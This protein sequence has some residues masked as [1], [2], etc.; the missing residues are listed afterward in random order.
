VTDQRA[1]DGRPAGPASGLPVGSGSLPVALRGR[2][3]L[4]GADDPTVGEP[5]PADVD[6]VGDALAAL[7]PALER[8][9]GAAPNN[10]VRAYPAGGSRSARPLPEHG[11]G[12]DVVL[13]ELSDA[14]DHGCRID[15]PGWFGFVTTG[16]T[17]SAV[18]AQ[19]AV[20]VAGGQRY[21][22]HA[23]NDL[24]WTALRWLAELCGIPAEA[25]GVF[26]SGGSTAN[27]V[28][29]GAARQAAFERIGVDVAEHGLPPGARTRI[30]ASR[31]AHRTIHRAAAALGLGRS[32]VREIATDRAGHVDIDAL[33][34]ALRE[35]RSEGVV[36]VAVVGVAGTTDTG[37][38]DPLS[39][40]VQVARDHDCWAH[41]DGAYGLMAYASRSARRLF[42]GV[43]D[44][45]SWIVD[46]H[47]WLATGVG[48]GAAYVRDGD[49]L[50]R[51]FS[52]GH[53]DY[54]EGS[55]AEPSAD[56]VSQFDGIGGPWADQ[57]VELS[58]P[59]RGALVWA[60]LREI[61]R[62]GVG[63]RVD[64]HLA[65]TR[66]LADQ[67]R[68][69]PRLEMLCEP[70]LSI[71]C[72][73]YK[74]PSGDPDAINARI[75]EHLRRETATVPTSTLVDGA[76]ALRPCIINPRTSRRD[77]DDLVR[78]TVAIGDTLSGATPEHQP[79]VP[80]TP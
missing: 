15:M 19:A 65:L 76:F 63:Q 80:G 68:R 54:L 6:R 55:F 38:V 29:L 12:L 62:A 33:A 8:A 74:P 30:Y 78:A 7:L 26:T 71:V 28:A 50:T 72:Y 61:G 79:S 11:A 18:A 2:P 77:V 48:V 17:T 41:V 34:A 66:R 69:H 49:L 70:D 27:L 47:K 42:A 5:D 40:V 73:R 24:E 32:S 53:A 52:E 67:I 59:P 46:P 45:D 51:A 1:A 39:K 22:Y 35:D 14:V 56:V 16:S 57:A 25:A 36:L 4:V 44:A 58:A 43:S 37:S 3:A 20:A 13:R 21:L 31:R 60:V 75:L 64:R 9:A 10:G 23:F